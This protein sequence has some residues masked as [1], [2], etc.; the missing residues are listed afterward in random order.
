[1]GAMRDTMNFLR[2]RRKDYQL[3][4]KQSVNGQNVLIDL[5]KFCRA[6]ETCVIPNDAV[7]TS[8][9]EG[10]REVWLRIANHIN[11]SDEQLYALLT[12]HNFNPHLADK[13]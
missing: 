5:A 12:G 1:M 9:L 4:F 13:D 8:I 10:R 2:R 3:T 11:L 6:N 7:L